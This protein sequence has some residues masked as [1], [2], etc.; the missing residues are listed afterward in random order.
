MDIFQNIK[1][2]LKLLI[3]I[4]LEIKHIYPRCDL[5]GVKL[6]IVTLVHWER[7]RRSKNILLVLC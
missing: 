2:N 5:V 6:K 4:Q 3:D 1:S 7:I